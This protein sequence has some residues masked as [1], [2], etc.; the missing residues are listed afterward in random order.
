M[1]RQIHRAVPGEFYIEPYTILYAPRARPLYV[2]AAAHAR[3]V[4]GRTHVHSN[5]LSCSSVRAVST[6]EDLRGGDSDM[7]PQ[8]LAFYEPGHFH[9]ALT[10]RVSNQRISNDVHVRIRPSLT[11]YPQAT[12]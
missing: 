11:H 1:S 10:L 9:A 2:P 7:A 12:A 8:T 4:R 6:K 3:S 5:E